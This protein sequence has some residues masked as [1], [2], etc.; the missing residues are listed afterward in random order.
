MSNVRFELNI[1]GLRDLMK[2]GEMKAILEEA[3]GTVAGH[4]S[5]ISGGKEFSHRVH[6]ASY[7]SIVNVF[8]GTKEA[9]KDNYDNNTLEKALGSC[10]LP[11][12][13]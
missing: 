6:D 8:P 10:G 1:N 7:V 9:A 5:A 3:G 13:K 11:R 4:A 12:Q 2:S